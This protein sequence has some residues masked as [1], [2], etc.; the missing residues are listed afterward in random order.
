MITILGQKRYDAVHALWAA[1][2]ISRMKPKAV[3]IELP[4]EFQSVLSKYQRGKINEKRLVSSFGRLLGK[5]LKLDKKALSSAIKGKI[6]R[7]MLNVP[8][9]GAFIYP[10][11][12][13]KKV[14][15]KIFAVDAPLEYV[16]ERVAPLLP[17]EIEGQIKAVN[18]ARKALVEP[19]KGLRLFSEL[20]H[21][22]V[23]FFEVIFGHNRGESPFLHPTHCGICR[24][25]VWWER[26]WH[27]IYAHFVSLA[28]PVKQSK[29]IA[30]LYYF[31][32]IREVEM[33]KG[34]RSASS[35]GKTIAVLHVWHA[36]AV[37]KRLKMKRLKVEVIT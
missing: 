23:H 19:D 29:Y 10:I 4:S 18:R 16:E 33:C 22:P 12:A 27:S 34:I 15:A 32:R 2:E 30:A 31:D 26:L 6:S 35:F 20:I 7:D 21:S 24:F 1:S 3:C 13:A 5:K 9:E 28:Y 36:F 37:E 14:K 11:I 8:T 17:L 25:G